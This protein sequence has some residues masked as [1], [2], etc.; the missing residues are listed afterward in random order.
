M[1]AAIFC[2]PDSILTSEFTTELFKLF[3]TTLSISVAHVHNTSGLAEAAVKRFKAALRAFI[4]HDQDNWPDFI[5]A[6]EIAFNT[7][8]VA[9]TQNTPFQLDT[10]RPFVTPALLQAG[11]PALHTTDAT[12][13]AQHIE[14][15]LKLARE[16]IIDTQESQKRTADRHRPP[17]TIK[18]N[19]LVYV[20]SSAFSDQ[21]QRNRPTDRLRDAW[22]GPYRVTAMPNP[23]SFT[24]ELPPESR[25]INRF[26]CSVLKLAIVSPDKFAS[27]YSFVPKPAI[28]PDQYQVDR[29]LGER[30]RNKTKEYL[31]HFT[32]YPDSENMW[33]T[34]NNVGDIHILLR[35]FRAE[36]RA[37]KP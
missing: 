24:L 4:S 29:V 7:T 6:L 8:K 28:A 26:H 14:Q 2:D 11:I 36:R 17:C 34:E 21:V 22:L 3:G 35:R 18:V 13:F 1:P 31:V 20:H 30:T 27:R 16:S 23:D 15:Q 12:A 10:G 33:I 25:A 32:G 19:D 5:D 37:S 9:T